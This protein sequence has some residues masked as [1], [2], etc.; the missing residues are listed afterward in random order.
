[1]TSTMINNAQT[2]FMN[3]SAGTVKNSENG[4]DFSK[5]SFSDVLGKQSNAKEEAATVAK[6]T[7]VSKETVRIQDKVK[8]A[9]ASETQPAKEADTK[10]DSTVSKKLEE[11][12]EEVVKELSEELGISEEELIAIME[13][14]GISFQEILQPGNL[15]QVVLQA[16][17][18]TDMLVLTTDENLYQTY[19]NICNFALQET[20]TVAEELGITQ[21]Q[22]IQAVT[23]QADMQTD[24]EVASEAELTDKELDEPIA[25]KVDVDTAVKESGMVET[26]EVKESE[27]EMEVTENISDEEGTK[28]VEEASD[29]QNTN[30]GST[31]KQAN[32]GPRT[33]VQERTDR[34]ER[35]GILTKNDI[36][37]TNSFT[38]QLQQVE[39][40]TTEQ[41][42]FSPQTRNIMNQIMDFMK[43][44]VHTEMTE[45][46]LQLQPESLGTLNVRVSAKEGV[47]TAQFAAETENV[48]AVLESQVIQLKETFAQQGIKVEA[49]EVTLASHEFERNLE[50]GKEREQTSED[51]KKRRRNINLSAIESIDLEEL[52]DADKIN[53]QMMEQNGNTVDYSA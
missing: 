8:N 31:S 12:G 9:E 30:E 4:M 36:A 16:S 46:Q 1:M 40:P 22:F 48:K 6:T 13:Q 53:A 34:P 52:E 18:E 25:I 11:A 32:G 23:E 42:Y 26:K 43:V 27:S 24:M 37:V 45:V 39:M 7:K 19:K 33:D 5:E 3:L 49:I 20:A 17:G 47:V 15:A 51:G 29:K 21:E 44:Q 41:T 28:V 50:Q 10:V 38:Q 2:L 14:L 35:Q